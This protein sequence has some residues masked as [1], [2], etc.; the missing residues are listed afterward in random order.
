MWATSA[1]YRFSMPSQISSPRRGKSRL[2]LF[3]VIT[4]LA[5]ATAT[6]TAQAQQTL[7]LPMEAGTVVV[8][9]DE[10]YGNGQ[11]HPTNGAIA[12]DFG[13]GNGD[14][15]FAV[16]AMGD[17]DARLVCTNSSGASMIAHRIDGYTGVFT[18]LHIQESSLPTWLTSDWT[19]VNQG[20]L[21]GRIFPGRIVPVDGE[22][23]QQFSSG[24]HLHLDLPSEGLVIDNVSWS[25]QSPNDLQTVQSTNRIGGPL[26][27]VICDGRIA[28]V[29]GTPGDDVLT[30]TNGPDVIAGLQGNDIIRGLA[31]D[32]VICGGKGNDTIIGGQ[33]FDVLFGAQGNDTLYAADGQRESER[34][35]TAGGRNFGGIGN[36]TIHGS[37]RWDRMQG[38][39]GADRL[40]GY[41]GRDWMRGGPGNDLVNSGPGQDDARGGNGTDT[42]V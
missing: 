12:F 37:T 38:G 17:G 19:P 4:L 8:Y 16:L 15:N 18:L 41:Q 24:P 35:D 36:D 27:E 31:G 7:R 34:F 13:A 40:Y 14:P 28:T 2:L 23:C 20:A 3:V 25:S 39:P 29:V 10:T 26:P 9:A 32:D 22:S 5:T 30:G 6:A 21:L 11:E 33:G 1:S 42:V